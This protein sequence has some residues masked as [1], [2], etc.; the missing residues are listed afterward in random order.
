LFLRGYFQNSDFTERNDRFI[1]PSLR[2]PSSSFLRAAD[3]AHL[4]AP[5]GIHVRLGDYRKHQHTHGILSGEY[6]SRAIKAVHHDLRIREVW[7]FSDDDKSA[8]NLIRETGTVSKLTAA[9]S[10]GLNDLETLFLLSECKNLV[11]GN[12]TFSLWAGLLGKRV[13][14]VV[15][16]DPAFV[17]IASHPNL[18]PQRFEKVTA[19]WDSA[20]YEAASSGNLGL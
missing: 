10:F 6:Y 12:S 13:D 14:Q 3:L 17:G 11:L 4:T 1:M 9:S 19:A 16:P 15:R 5:L 2:Q 20:K 7:V 18:Y 8:M